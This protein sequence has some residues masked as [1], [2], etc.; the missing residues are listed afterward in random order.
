M[1]PV[2]LVKLRKALID[3]VITAIDEALRWPSQ[4]FAFQVILG[5]QVV[6]SIG[7]SSTKPAT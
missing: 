7:R 1:W 4:R 6:Y 5:L 3:K 2:F